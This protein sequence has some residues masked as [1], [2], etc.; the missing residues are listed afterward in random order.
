VLPAFL[1]ELAE[2]NLRPTVIG[3]PVRV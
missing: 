3:E 2:R 1:A